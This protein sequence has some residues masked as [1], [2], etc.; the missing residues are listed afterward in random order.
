MFLSYRFRKPNML[1]LHLKKDNNRLTSLRGV[2][3]GFYMSKKNKELKTNG[4]IQLPLSRKLK[5]RKKKLS[6][7]SRKQWAS[8]FQSQLNQ[9]NK[10][11]RTRKWTLKQNQNLLTE[12]I[13]QE[14]DQNPK[15][16]KLNDK[17]YTVVYIFHN[18]KLNNIVQNSS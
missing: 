1:I 9:R 17:L 18:F 5:T 10:N 8:Q 6:K 15:R 16:C 4:K 7:T 2:R 11:Q 14:K 13:H 3:P 12:P